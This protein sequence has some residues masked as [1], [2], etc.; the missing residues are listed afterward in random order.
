MRR[1]TL[2]IAIA[3]IVAV[4]PATAATATPSAELKGNFSVQFPQGHPPKPGP[5]PANDFCGVGSLVN[6][7]KATITIL[8]DNFVPIDGTPCF[9]VTSDEVIHLLD[10]TG[11]LAYTTIGIFCSPGGSGDSNAGPNS[12]GHPGEWFARYTIDGASSTGVFAGA[13]GTGVRWFKSAG[14]R[15]LW[16]IQGNLNT[17]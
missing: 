14:G 10:G 9:D 16:L 12:Y 15:G 5:C 8:D 11:D 7:G 3:A 2:G 13:S 4:L 6:Y 1:L 17:V